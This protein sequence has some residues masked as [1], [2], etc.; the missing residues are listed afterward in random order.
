MGEMWKDIE[1]YEGIYQISNLGDVKSYDKY[2]K[3]KHGLIFYKGKKM[4]IIYS[5]KYPFIGLTKNRKQKVHLIHRL[6]AIHFIPNPENKSQVNHKKGIKTDNRA[7]ELEWV[8]PS[9]NIIHAYQT[10]LRKKLFGK[11]HKG[12]K[13]VK[14]FTMDGKFISEYNSQLEAKRMLGMKSSHISEVCLGKVASCG[15]YLWEYA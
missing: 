13:K 8:T 7:S 9:E 1:D 11:D 10:G 5:G 2:V 12:S 4:K 14:Q 15:G 6:V 3:K